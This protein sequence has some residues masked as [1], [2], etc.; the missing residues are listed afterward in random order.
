MRRREGRS[1]PRA[2][3]GPRAA[4]EDSR[5]PRY[6]Q[7]RS[8]FDDFWGPEEGTH[9]SKP[10]KSLRLGDSSQDP[11]S[12]KVDHFCHPEES[13]DSSGPPVSAE[14]RPS[15]PNADPNVLQPLEQLEKEFNLPLSQ[16][17]VGRF[18]PQFAKARK[19]GAR[20]VG[21]G[22]EAA[23]SKRRLGRLETLPQPGAQPAG[24]QLFGE[25]QELNLQEARGLGEQ[26]QADDPC[27]EQPGLKFVTPVPGSD[28]SPPEF[29]PQVG[30]CDLERASLHPVSE[31]GNSHDEP[32]AQRPQGPADGDQNECQPGSAEEEEETESGAPQDG[33]EAALPGMEQEEGD[34]IPGSP[35]SISVLGSAQGR[36]SPAPCMKTPLL[37]QGIPEPQQLHS[38]TRGEADQSCPLGSAT[39]ETLVITTLSTDPWVLG[40][41]T[42]EEAGPPA[43]PDNQAPDRDISWALLGSMPPPEEATGGGGGAELEGQP[44]SDASA[45]GNREPMADPGDPGLVIL[46]V[47]PVVDQTQDPRGGGV[48]SALPS[49]VQPAPGEPA[50]VP[51]QGQQDLGELQPSPQV[52]SLLDDKDTGDSPLQE[53]AACPGSTDT[54]PHSPGPPQLSQEAS[55]SQV[56]WPESPAMDLDFLLDSQIQD[57]LDIPDVELPSEQGF[58]EGT[59]PGLAWP[60]PSPGATLGASVKMTEAQPRPVGGTQVPEASLMEDATNIV[61]GLIMELSNLNRLIMSTHRDLEVCKR[62]SSRKTKAPHKVKGALGEQGW[63]VL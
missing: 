43:S 53:T 37:V 40:Q 8:D 29:C 63:R 2:W 50:A 62:L 38:E 54:S 48:T 1:P 11:Q 59:T 35:A 15:S 19:T 42:L 24:T 52:P 28:D 26:T 46:E 39:M 23:P 27:S 32:E 60:S 9:P 17:S 44:P 57:A 12:D 16:S 6:H 55:A 18:V 20:N 45:L 49:L 25:P 7:G 34:H 33:T 56:L 14:L 58:P 51:S 47:G 36:G 22:A 61:R 4:R 31:L 13:E 41:R 30:L 10:S 3:A 5:R 21:A